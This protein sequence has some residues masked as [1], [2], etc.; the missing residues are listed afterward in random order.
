VGGEE[1]L[2][3]RE[4]GAVFKKQQQTGTGGEGLSHMGKWGK[5]R[6][7]KLGWKWGE[8]IQQFKEGSRKV[9]KKGGFWGGR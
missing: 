6:Q 3:R 5:K 9:K 4:D 7:K 2:V 1:G 8:G